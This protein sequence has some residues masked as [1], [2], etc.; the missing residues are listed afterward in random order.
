M[1][2]NK[3]IIIFLFVLLIPCTNLKA[4]VLNLNSNSK[5]INLNQDFLVEFYLD[6][7][8]EQINALEGK[9]IFPNSLLKLKEIQT[10]NSIVSLWL[11]E[12]NQKEINQVSFS[13]I[14]PGGINDSNAFIFSMIFEA[15]QQGNENI[16][17]KDVQILL[18]DGQGTPAKIRFSNFDFFISKL[19]EKEEKKEPTPTAINI[20][21][22]SPPELFQPIISQNPN[23]FNN[24]LFLVFVTQD[25]GS[26]IDH[27]EIKEGFNAFV[28][29]K[30]PYL[31]KNQK[32][33]QKIIVRAVDKNK[34]IREV[35]LFPKQNIFKK[36]LNYG[37][38]ILGVIVLILLYFFI[39]KRK[40][41]N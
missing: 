20:I 8:Q 37:I 9:I 3:K 23:L 29:A 1:L 17:F 35:I 33:N 11:E 27:Y 41:D 5:N 19:E 25:K 22:N 39:K 32:I 38:M 2:L 30:S 31:L 16:K 6:T 14:I 7:Q 4:T 10:G 40:H 34:N 24:Q 18:N 36:F 15:R 26:G 13:G 21:D 28:F 12:P